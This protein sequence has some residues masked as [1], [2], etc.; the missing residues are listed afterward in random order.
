MAQLSDK[1]IPLAKA[2]PE[3]TE[4]NQ[5]FS[6]IGDYLH[7]F[8]HDNSKT[9]KILKRI[10]CDPSYSGINV[11]YMNKSFFRIDSDII[12]N[13]CNCQECIH[14]KQNK[15]PWLNSISKLKIKSISKKG[16]FGFNITW[17]DNHTSRLFK[18][19]EIN[20]LLLKGNYKK[21]IKF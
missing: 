7:K 21:T 6:E 15:I 12:R 19:S 17:E 11:H 5:I 10:D 14:S 18:Y 13:N 3:D 8:L 16:S 4:I 1:G 2:V 9:N 20:D